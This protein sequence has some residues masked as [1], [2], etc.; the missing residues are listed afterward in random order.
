MVREKEGTQ[1][2][3][4]YADDGYWRVMSD[5]NNI[6][7]FRDTEGFART[8]ESNLAWPYDCAWRVRYNLLSES[9][10]EPAPDI[11]VVTLTE[12]ET[13]FREVRRIAL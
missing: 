1:M 2:S 13:T 12:D 10:M 11:R 4:M 9:G 5:E 8:E 6:G 7:D 3:L